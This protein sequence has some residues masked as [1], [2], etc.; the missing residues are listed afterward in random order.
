MGTDISRGWGGKSVGVL[1]CYAEG[2][3]QFGAKFWQATWKGS[4]LSL[5]TGKGRW[6]LNVCFWE[7]KESRGNEDPEW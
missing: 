5:N 1:G 3:F 7:L 2:P 4:G 6:T